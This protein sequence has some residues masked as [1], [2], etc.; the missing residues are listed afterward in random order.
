MQIVF[1][2]LL[3]AGFYP[4]YRAWQA[5]KRTT[6]IHAIAWAFLAWLAWGAALILGQP[7][8]TGADPWRYVGLCLTG[9]AGSRRFGRTPVRKPAHGTWS[10]SV[11]L[12]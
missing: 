1:S 2:L 11:C 5:N 9:A 12:P 8:K 4:F 10:L 3:V 6:L 7:Y